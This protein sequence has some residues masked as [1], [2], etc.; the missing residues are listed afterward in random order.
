ME[1]IQKIDAMDANMGGTEILYPLRMCLQK[2]P[3]EDYPRQIFLLTDGAVSDTASVQNFVRN[4]NKF[5]RVHGIGIGNGASEDLILGCA[6]QGKG[7]SV[8]ISDTEDPTDKIIDI[9]DKSLSPAISKI[10]LN[11][12]KE[13]VE[14]V[15]PNPEKNPYILKN[16]VAN[17]YFT[18][19]GKLT[20]LFPVNISF[21]D[22]LGVQ[23]SQPVVINP[24]SAIKC[25]YLTK[26]VGHHSLNALYTVYKYG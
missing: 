21:T 26:V 19:H 18:F 22:S 6:Q 24:Q 9:L 12:D 3:I 1:A 17:F 8:M 2:P 10:Q 23:Y 16:E 15:V 25:A 4:H 5:S 7:Y 11:F 14:S 20:S 13:R